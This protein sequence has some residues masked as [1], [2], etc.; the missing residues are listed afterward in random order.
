MRTHQQRD[1]AR[2]TPSR[3]RRVASISVEALEGRHSMSTMMPAMGSMST[4]PAMG[5]MMNSTPAVTSIATPMS[6]PMQTSSSTSV[7]M[8]V[9]HSG[10]S[11]RAFSIPMTFMM[12]P[13]IS[14]MQTFGMAVNHPTVAET[15]ASLK[16]V[17]HPVISSPFRPPT[18]AAAA[19]PERS[20]MLVGHHAT[21]VGHHDTQAHEHAGGGH[22]GHPRR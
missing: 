12:L 10:G 8:T 11:A 5:S 14:R 13:K 18:P 21:L 15:S 1:N 20:V 3:T 9:S 19:S 4:M 22:Q 16:I 6:Q 7:E 17:S 2:T